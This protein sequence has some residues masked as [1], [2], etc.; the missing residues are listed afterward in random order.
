MECS[1]PALPFPGRSL[2]PSST[3]SP[4]YDKARVWRAGSP[5]PAVPRS[6]HYLGVHGTPRSRREGGPGGRTQQMLIKYVLVNHAGQC[7]GGDGEGTARGLRIHPSERETGTRE[8]SNQRPPA[9]GLCT[10][11]DA[12][13]RD[14]TEAIPAAVLP[15]LGE[16]RVSS[17]LGRGRTR[18]SRPLCPGTDVSGGGSQPGPVDTAGAR[19]LGSRLC[20]SLDRAGRP[21]RTEQLRNCSFSFVLFLFS[22]QKV[23]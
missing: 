16:R 21:R 10:G 4:G 22:P 8:T 2:Y 13:P 19:R 3:S 15:L 9:L 7:L 18:C 11:E 6:A 1:A 14:R 17:P 23:L 20:L 12:G 5:A